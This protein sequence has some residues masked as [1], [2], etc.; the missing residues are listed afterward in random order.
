MVGAS[1]SNQTPKI[2]ATST[3][4]SFNASSNILSTYDF[5]AF[6]Y[7][8]NGGN[9]LFRRGSA[10]GSTNHIN[11][12]DSTGDP[13]SV[14]AEGAGTGI[15]W[16]QR[17]DS[18]PYYIMRMANRNF[19]GASYTKLNLNWHTG[20]VIG[21]NASYGGTRFYADAYPLSETLNFHINGG[22]NHTYKYTW[23]YT[24]TTGFYSDTNNWHIEPNSGSSYGGTQLR[25]V[26]NG[27][28]GI[29]FLSGGNTPHVMF[30]G[31]ANGGFYY[32]ST[33]RWSLYY[34]HGNAS[35]GVNTSTTS[36]SYA[37]YSSG[38]IYTTGNIDSASDARLKDNVVTIE[39]ALDKVL[40]LRGV[41]FTWNNLEE[42]DK[43]YGKTQM[44]F[45]AQEIEPIIPEVVTYAED[46]DQY[47]VNYGQIT[48]LLTE[49]IKE[50]NEVINTLRTEIENLKK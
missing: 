48:A 14:V 13:S 23:M 44:G 39:S 36:S 38:S 33:G 24:N 6:R 42:D 19:G 30:D 43:N 25:G 16:G 15:T 46:V 1:G 4:L 10:S 2:R 34:S 8:D 7:Y 11:L 37:I 9:F 21:S 26:R 49:A 20:I 12:A 47:A 50:Q 41:N 28:Y 17:S 22:S 3:A 45:I 27:W 5:R 32:E 31:S 35:W 18:Q 40:K 29:H